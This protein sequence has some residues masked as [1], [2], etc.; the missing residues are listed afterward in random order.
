MTC[1]A[2]N[3]TDDQDLGQLFEESCDVFT[4]AALSNVSLRQAAAG[5]T[6]SNYVAFVEQVARFFALCGPSL[7]RVAA[8]MHDVPPRWPAHTDAEKQQHLEDVFAELRSLPFAG[9]IIG[10]AGGRHASV[11]N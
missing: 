3:H 11:M 6:D 10:R 9:G 2:G 4:D 5:L 8:A 7:L 1:S